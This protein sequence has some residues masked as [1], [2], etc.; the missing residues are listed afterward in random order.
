[1]RIHWTNTALGH[2]LSIYEYIWQNSPAYADRVIDRLTRRSEQIEAFP[3]SGR[4]VP[5]YDREDV[6][7][8]IEKP[9]R[10]IYRIGEEQVD[11]RTS[12]LSSC[13]AT[14]SE[15]VRKRCV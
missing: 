10:I 4:R 9:S 7:E 1:V 5:E 2:L 12:G 11:V 6:R 14:T 13:A 3:D 15:A 8:V